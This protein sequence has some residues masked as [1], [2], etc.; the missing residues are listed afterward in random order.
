MEKHEFPEKR[1][2]KVLVEELN[3]EIKIPKNIMLKNIEGRAA[4]NVES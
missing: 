2:D 4:K 3:L 1:P